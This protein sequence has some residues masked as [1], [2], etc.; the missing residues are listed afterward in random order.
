[1]SYK[2]EKF[3][4]PETMST[5]SA[6]YPWN[7]NPASIL[8]LFFGTTLMY[9]TFF[10]GWPKWVNICAFMFWRLC[11]DVGLGIILTYQS[12]HQSVTRLVERLL[13]DKSSPLAAFL[14]K[15][16]G[17]ALPKEYAVKIDSYPSGFQAWLLYKH[18]VNIVLVNDGCSYVLLGF[19]CF[20][21]PDSISLVLIG[22]YLVGLFLC[23]FNYWAKVDAHRCIGEYCWYWGDFFYIKHQNLTFDGIF[24]LFP[25]PMYTVGYSMY[26]GYSLICRSYTMLFVSLF[27][28]LLQIAFLALVEEPH[29]EKT[30]GSGETM[31][32]ERLRVL[33]DPKSGLFPQKR[34]S[35]FFAHIDLFTSGDFALICLAAYGLFLSI[36][37]DNPVWCIAQVIVW[38]LIHWLGLG[39]VLWLQS[40]RQWWT[41]RFTERG[42]PLYEA[43]A[44][45]KQLY[46]LS[47]TMNVVVF[48]GCAIRYSQ[49]NFP[50]DLLAARP[51]AYAVLGFVLILL[52][53]WSSSSTYNSVGDFGWFYGD[54][55]IA[56]DAYKQHLCYTGIYRFLNNPDCITGYAGLYGLSLI[57]RSWIIFFLAA[58]AQTLNLVFLNL[59]EIPHMEKLYAQKVRQQGPIETA[60]VKQITKAIPEITE[61]ESKLKAEAREARLK[62]MTQAYE[63]FKKLAEQS[64][65]ARPG[66]VSL[67][68][69]ESIAPGE[70]LVVNYSSK[71]T[72]DT[73][74]I[75]VYPVNA[76]SGP[77]VA[78]GKWVY[79]NSNSNEGSVKIPPGLL[80]QVEGVY[81]IRYHPNGG[82]NTLAARTLLISSD[83]SITMQR[84]KE[85]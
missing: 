73:D 6:F 54:F 66:S 3:L 60:I 59:V 39:T 71:H 36:T 84:S 62:A 19:K 2:G 28:H 49:F 43:F 78:D 8:S 81:E 29:I 69:P 5:V 12:K 7:L 83:A 26:Y 18:L 31:D 30:Y 55:F 38:R 4:V 61:I 1:M 44:H 82:Y 68:A 53:L 47:L 48:V 75:A 58:G 65:L 70:P 37:V 17:A 25:H 35:V 22:Q 40:N 67:D 20:N 64:N 16:A 46:N 10:A 15:L 72:H 45:W 24:E 77:G 80:P 14:L 11:Y 85:D 34:D 52:N 9:I 21:A 42:R 32:K 57:S 50:E 41:R 74:W 76:D 63:I 51:M 56:A 27:A 13:A 79:V 23:L 33:Y